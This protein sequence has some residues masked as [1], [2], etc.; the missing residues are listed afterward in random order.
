MAVLIKKGK[1]EDA[2]YI[3]FEP[4]KPKFRSRVFD[5]HGNDEIYEKHRQQD[6]HATFSYIAKELRRMRREAREEFR[7]L[8]RKEQFSVIFNGKKGMEHI[9]REEGSFLEKELPSIICRVSRLVEK[10]Y[11][12]YI[13]WARK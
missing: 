5:Y 12:P 9:L 11:T 3:R 10:A 13:K 8:P 2:V 4:I 1:G 7:E 6:N